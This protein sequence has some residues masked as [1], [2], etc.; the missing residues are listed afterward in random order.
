MR[1]RDAR[2]KNDP[3]YN[4]RMAKLYREVVLKEKPPQ[5]ENGFIPLEVLAKP[6]P[7]PAPAQVPE[8]VLGD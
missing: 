3:A 4:E 1:A 2:L 6:K 7:A 8:E 5:P